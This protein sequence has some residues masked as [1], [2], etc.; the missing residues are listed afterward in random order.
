MTRG[1][2]TCWLLAGCCSV[3]AVAVASAVAFPLEDDLAVARSFLPEDHP[4]RGSV[5]LQWV[6]GLHGNG[7]DEDGHALLGARSAAD[8]VIALNTTVRT[9]FTQCET[10][11]LIIHEVGH[12]AGLPDSTGIMD[13]GSEA[14]ERVAVPGC[15]A[16]RGALSDRVTAA[17]LDRV[18]RGWAV[19]CGARRGLVVR[20]RAD[21]GRGHSRRF[22]VR[23][24]DA[25]WSGF[26]VVR[27]R[28]GR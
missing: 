1:W 14:R 6:P 7:H 20:C 5:M 17:V 25:V 13:T 15:R 21:D 12:L 10:R 24:W 19:S 2:R 28:K 8:C 27:V 9:D 11:R 18:P 16:R 4:C 3:Y 23:A 26:S 22:R